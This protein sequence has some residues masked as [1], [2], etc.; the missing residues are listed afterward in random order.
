MEEAEEWTDRREK[1]GRWNILGQSRICPHCT[2][3]IE[4]S[5]HCQIELVGK[6]DLFNL[7]FLFWWLERGGINIHE[8]F[9]QL[10]PLT[11]MDWGQGQAV[12]HHRLGLM[13]QSASGLVCFC[14]AELVEGRWG[15]HSSGQGRAELPQEGR[16]AQS[17]VCVDTGGSISMQAHSGWHGCSYWRRGPAV[18]GWMGAP[19]WPGMVWVALVAIG[20]LFVAGC[21]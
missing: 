14:G 6:T 19:T 18:W 16:R 17:W 15:Q 13:I 21:R 11:R 12:G 5:S 8:A 4:L 7:S 1:R 9:F 20:A 3:L 2:S 10:L